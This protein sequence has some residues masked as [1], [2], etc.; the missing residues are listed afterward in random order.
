MDVWRRSL[1][2]GGFGSPDA[3]AKLRRVESQGNMHAPECEESGR[4]AGID[5]ALTRPPIC[6][7]LTRIDIR[8]RASR[9]CR[10]ESTPTTVN[11]PEES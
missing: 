2:P 5:P 7:T 4:F 9:E 3:C 6:P 11:R 8:G 1:R 10:T